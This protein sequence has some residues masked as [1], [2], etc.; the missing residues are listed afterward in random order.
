MT[1]LRN[2]GDLKRSREALFERH[3]MLQV[4]YILI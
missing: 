4:S 3:S 2:Q 1:I